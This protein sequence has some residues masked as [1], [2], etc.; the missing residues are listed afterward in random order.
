MGLDVYL[1]KCKDLSA[2]QAYEKKQSEATDEIWE[3]LKGEL[4]LAKDQPLSDANYKEY[5]RRE[6]AWAKKN[7]RPAGAEDTEVS[8]NSEKYPEHMFKIGYFRS[9]YNDGGTNTILRNAIGMD[10]YSIFGVDREYEFKPDWEAS[11]VRAKEAREK[12]AQFVGDFGEIKV[13]KVH[14]PVDIKLPGSKA[15]ALEI[16][17]KEV[18]LRKKAPSGFNWYSNAQ[19]DFFLNKGV[20][21]LAAMQGKPEYSF[22]G[23]VTTYLVIRDVTEDKD[24]NG[25][26]WYLSALDIVIETIEYV[27]RHKDRSEFYFHW[28]G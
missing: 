2:K 5:R 8:L 16:Y 27:L 4:G 15:E 1:Y 10:L 20:E 26:N 28:S 7:P 17:K 3:K 24:K 25:P 23:P 9:S 19:G 21:V 11:L 14:S 13:I 12:Y 22:E 6:K 18:L